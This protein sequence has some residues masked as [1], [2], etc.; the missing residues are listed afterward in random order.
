M[1][2]YTSKPVAVS[3]TPEQLVEKFSDFSN[4]QSRM[5]ALP[6]EQRDQIGDVTFTKDTIEI[7]TP[8]VGKIIMRAI[9]RTDH[10]VVMQAESS[11]VPMKIDIRFRPDATGA[12][13]T[14]A[15]DVDI[16]VMLRP[17]VGPAL[18]KAV[19]QFGTL[20]AKLA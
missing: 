19:D 3:L 8:Q 20:F 14:S 15:M 17:L 16:P 9:E 5:E 18:Q 1:A 12:E 10:S 6:K 7:S 11:P 13:V 2:T 4:M